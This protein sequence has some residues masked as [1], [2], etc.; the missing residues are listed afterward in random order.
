LHAWRLAFTHPVSGK[1]LVFKAALPQD[2][3]EALADWGVGYN[4]QQDV[5]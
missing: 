4:A 5:L 1:E 3:R 2:M